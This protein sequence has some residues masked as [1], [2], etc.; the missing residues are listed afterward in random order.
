MRR[1][2]VGIAVSVAP[3]TLGR[4]LWPFVDPTRA[5]H[6][7]ARVAARGRA[8]AGLPRPGRRVRAAGRRPLLRRDQAA[9]GPRPRSRRAADARREGPARSR[10]REVLGRGHPPPR[11]PR[12]AALRR[13]A[14]RARRDEPPHVQTSGTHRRLR[15]L[16]A[17]GR[18]AGRDLEPRPRA[19]VRHGAGRGGARARQVRAP[20]ARR[21]HPAHAARRARL[22]VP[23]RGP[24]PRGAHGRAVDRGA[25]IPRRR[26][27]RQ[28]LRAQQPGVGARHHQRRGRRTR[29]A[30]DL[31]ARLRGR[32]EG[33][34]RLDDHGRL[35]P[36]PR[37]AR[38]PQ[39]VPARHD[40]QGRVG[41]QGRRDLRLERHARHARG[42]PQRPRSRDGDRAQVRQFLPGAP[43]PRSRDAG[44]VA[45]VHARGQ[46]PAQPPRDV[47]DEDLRRG[48][49]G[50][51]RGLARHRGPSP[52]GP[53][54]RRGVDGPPEERRRPP[55]A[56]ARRR[57][58]DRRHRRERHAPARARGRQLRDQ[59][60]LRGDAPRGDHG[61]P[62]RPRE[63]RLRARLS[64]GRPGR[65]RS[66]GRGRGGR[67]A[68]GRRRRRRR[69]QPRPL[70]REREHRP[71]GPRPPRWPGRA[72]RARGRRQS[73]DRRRPRL[74]RARA[75]G[76]VAPRDPLRRAGVVRGPGGRQRAR[77][78]PLRR[79]L[80]VGK[81]AVHV[82]APPRGLARAR[83]GRLP[84]RRTASSAT[85]KGCSS[86]TAGSTPRRSSPCSRSV[87]ACRT[88]SSRIRTS[89]SPR[90]AAVA[91]RV[92]L[93]L[94]NVG[95]R[96]GSETV[97]VY[98]PR[99]RAR[100][101]G[102]A[103]TAREGAQGFQ[104]G[105]ARAGRAARRRDPAARRRLRALR[106][107]AQGLGRGRGD[108]PDPRGRVLARRAPH[109]HAHVARDDERGQ[110]CPPE[111]R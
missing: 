53:P 24:V 28:A 39:P 74:G 90:P 101:R 104:Q 91:A 4:Q 87:T 85:K 73:Q 97:Q 108:V 10:R 107:G 17:R 66:A 71:E 68:R 2:C 40:P 45:D 55:A 65:P 86:A 63:R 99:R 36:G 60:A 41:L 95:R 38:L 94:A 84:G 52:R 110:A 77:P 29:A 13:P 50:S 47:R 58:H 44:D 54:H 20:R 103:L 93:E 82:P 31:P 64:D 57:P 30:R 14:R 22:R 75:H 102:A 92:R 42:G 56:W 78:H 26:G 25:A 70:R 88:R 16:A 61:A 83:A 32:R 18:R 49:R 96:A 3:G 43:L 37:P 7:R 35:Q 51:G 106:S 48:R 1:P 12:A 67:E 23:E 27:L 21:Q 59:G 98:V 105:L 33:G 34:G 9:R 100:S 76:P 109:G 6:V 11:D 79:R 111:P 46:G 89:P 62:R 8:A 81:A 80:P 15:D 5:F 69:P 19:R 72:D